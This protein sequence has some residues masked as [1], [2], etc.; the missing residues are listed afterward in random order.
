MK[1]QQSGFA[2]FTMLMIVITLLGILTAVVST[3]RTS[4]SSYGD[5]QKTL[6]MGVIGQGNALVV[7][8]QAMEG[9][10]TSPSSITFDNAAT[11][12]LLNPIDGGSS[13]QTP[14]FQAFAPGSALPFW[15][16]KGQ[17][18]RVNSV[19][20]SGVSEYAFV[21]RGLTQAA[22]QQIN[23]RLY[24]STVIPASGLMATTWVPNSTLITSPTETTSVNIEA[25]AGV[26]RWMVGCVSSSDGAPEYIYFV[27]AEPQ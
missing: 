11:T 5:A 2:V 26:A 1:R 22:C 20:S 10:G 4:A 24:G 21:L 17:N 3:S 12:G 27:V 19:G 14:P 18:V 8:F 13:I 9:R 6:A 23:N 16:Y 7:G 15:V 25:V